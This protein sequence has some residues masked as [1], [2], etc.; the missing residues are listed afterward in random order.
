MKRAFTLLEILVALVL[1][2]LL[3]AVAVP[4]AGAL[5]GADLRTQTGLLTGAIRDTY[6]RTALQGRSARLVMDFEKNAWWIEEA[7]AVA[8]LHGKD[9]GVDRDGKGQ[10]DPVDERVEDIDAD[11]DDEGERTKLELLSPPPFKPLEG[12]DGLPRSLGSD[13]RFKSLWAE[14]LDDKVQGGQVALYFFP[15]GFTEEALL[16]L[17]DDDQGERTL[18]LVVS[19]LT[20]EVD[21]VDEEPRIPEVV[22]D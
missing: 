16:T 18:T 14:H 21:V 17:T 6:A 5:S 12:E 7:E 20:G 3:V 13:V 4:A 15:G 22:E 2:S 11:T 1:L 19:S 9:K 8:R 10:L